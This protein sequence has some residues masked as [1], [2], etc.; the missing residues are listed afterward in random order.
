MFIIELLSWV[1]DM[2]T[3]F[4]TGVVKLVTT[5][6]MGETTPEIYDMIVVDTG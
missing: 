4:Q 1:I 5:I 2:T 6:D 3:T